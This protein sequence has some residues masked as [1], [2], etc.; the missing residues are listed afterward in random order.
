[1]NECRKIESI[2]YLYRKGELSVNESKKV[3]EH[4]KSCSR[5]REI[6]QQLLSIDIAL[7][8]LR[9]KIP[10]LSGDAPLVNE[11][12]NRFAKINISSETE[13][14]KFLDLDVLFG[15][16]RPA[17]SFIVLAATVLF[18]TQ[19]WQDA[20]KIS[21][22]E[23]H[24][25]TIEGNVGS[26]V[27]YTD[28]DVRRIIG[29]ITIE[30]KQ[31]LPSAINSAAVDA[32]PIRLIGSELLKLFMKKNGLFDYLSSRYPN[33]S[34]VTLEDGINDRERKIIATEGKALMKEFEQ[35]LQEGEK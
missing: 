27:S 35:L 32:N 19:Q 13:G 29:K 21:G 20:R 6:I 25:R 31:G 34:S 30:N 22:L 12:I 26:N 16:L 8:Q 3:L 15:W 9:E 28:F 11:T 7:L 18:V 10:D 5:C 24:L 2:I 4:T 17:L 1:M 33:L 23:I 14:K